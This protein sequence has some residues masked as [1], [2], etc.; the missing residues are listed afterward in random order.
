MTV[1]LSSRKKRRWQSA[2]Q[3]RCVY[4][5]QLLQNCTP[6]AQLEGSMCRIT[7]ASIKLGQHIIMG[8][9][10]CALSGVLSDLLQYWSHLHE[11]FSIAKTVDARHQQRGKCF[12]GRK[13]L[14]PAV[15]KA[16]G[17]CPLVPTKGPLCPLFFVMA[18]L[19]RNRVPCEGLAV[20]CWMMQG[21]EAPEVQDVSMQKSCLWSVLPICKRNAPGQLGRKQGRKTCRGWRGEG[22]ELRG[23][24][25]EGWGYGGTFDDQTE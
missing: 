23:R 15:I 14:L 11:P 3:L 16:Q 9:Y 2:I 19:S 22:R 7:S 20:Q 21:T 8:R 18:S 24:Q 6:T 13:L 5:E 1:P 12:S 17:N 4:G 10:E 25:K